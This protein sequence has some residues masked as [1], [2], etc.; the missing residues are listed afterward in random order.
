MESA[1]QG[2]IDDR[3]DGSRVNQSHGASTRHGGS[4]LEHAI[5]LGAGDG[6]KGDVEIVLRGVTIRSVIAARVQ[7]VDPFAG[8]LRSVFL[9]EFLRTVETQSFEPSAG[10]FLQGQTRETSPRA[11]GVPGHVKT[12]FEGTRQRG[13]VLQGRRILQFH[14]REAI[15]SQ[16]L[17]GRSAGLP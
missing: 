13:G 7:V 16:P 5:G 1:S 9:G 15:V 17:R 11:G 6:G 8:A 12:T 10:Q 2:L 3:V 14:V 4:K